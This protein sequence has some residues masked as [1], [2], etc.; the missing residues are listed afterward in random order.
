VSYILNALRKSEAERRLG[1]SPDLHT[2]PPAPVQG[3]FRRRPHVLIFALAPLL[4]VTALLAWWLA[5]PLGLWP[6]ADREPVAEPPAEA[7]VTG[8]PGDLDEDVVASRT[9][10]ESDD[11]APADDA[12]TAQTDDQRAQDQLPPIVSRRPAPQRAVDRPRAPVASERPVERPEGTQRMID[13][14]P[15]PA[16]PPAEQRRAAVVQSP[17]PASPELQPEAWT[18]ER[19]EFMRQWELPLAI[20]RDLPALSLNIHVFS[21]EP[22]GRFVLINGERR[23][24]GDDLGQG[25]RLVEIRREGALVA[26]RDYHFLLEP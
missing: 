14:L 9:V 24:E 4:V 19:S 26:F 2:A 23:I 20:R 3:R 18:P 10:A 7:V 13:G 5:E 11:E 21:A 12:A 1:Q 25:A 15:T 17:A 6:V 8:L 16:Q 22:R